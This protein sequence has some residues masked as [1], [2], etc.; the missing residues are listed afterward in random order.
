MCN[1]VYACLLAGGK[2]TRLWPLSVPSCSKSFVR[3]GK[4]RPLIEDTISRLK[5]FINKE[6]ILVVVDKK[7]AGL[8]GKF[9]KGIPRRNIL[10]EPFGRSTASAI[11]LAAIRLL[12][13]D[14]IAALPTDQII[15]NPAGFR[16]TIKK[17]ADFARKNKNS[18]LCV[19]VKPEGPS[20][21]YGYIKA[22]KNRG[23]GI[24]KVAGFM[25]KPDKKTAKLF[26]KRKNFFWNAGIYIFRA[27]SILSA[28]KRHAP[29]LR[30][31]LERVRKD[32]KKINSAYSRMKNVSIDYQIA[33]RSKDIYF[34]RA[35]FGWRDLGSWAGLDEVL[36]KAG[37]RKDGD[38]NIIFGKARLSGTANSV[39]YNTESFTLIVEGARDRIIAH[40]KNGTL[41]CPKSEAGNIKKKV[42]TFYEK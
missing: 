10:V 12:P 31:E 13:E 35:D 21:A 1:G 8:L 17:A 18:L 27:D 41:V 40:T 25:E 23:G 32:G 19:G 2:G 9:T 14:V 34:I 6:R 11:G 30:R 37:A 38:G 5:G 29:L 4:R 22:G 15:T 7:Q 28:M 3:I 24:R 39:I 26:V 36:L 42:E 33:E 16:K 20:T